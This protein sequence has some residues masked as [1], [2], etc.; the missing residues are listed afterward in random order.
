MCPIYV[1]LYNRSYGVEWAEGANNGPEHLA[2]FQV[3]AY[4]DTYKDTHK[5]TYKDTHKDT[6]KDTHKDTYKDTHKD[7][8][9]DTRCLP[10]LFCR[11]IRPLLQ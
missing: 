9:K 4:K 8:Y 5:D 10:G 3:C 11:V 1:S 7:T 6:Y 2:A